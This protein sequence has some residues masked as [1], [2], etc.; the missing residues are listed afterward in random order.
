MPEA[1]IVSAVRTAVAKGKADG[2]LARAGVA[3]IDTS[4]PTLHA[5]RSLR[6]IACKTQ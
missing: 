1:V 4:A 2:A 3:P 5:R 6:R